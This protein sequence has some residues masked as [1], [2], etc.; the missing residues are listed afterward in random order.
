V[1]DPGP[2]HVHVHLAVTGAFPLQVADLLFADER[3]LVPEYEYVTPLF[4]LARGG[5][6]EAGARARTRHED[7]GVPALLDL[8]ERT[9]RI[10]YDDVERVRVHESRVGRPK[11]AVD[12]ADDPPLG[13]RVHAPVEIDPLAGALRSLGQRRGFPVAERA[14]LGFSPH[15]S[16]RRF[17][18]GR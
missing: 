3:L 6:A 2:V 12:L 17:V 8:A 10:P 16:L 5:L 7:G 1:T 9:L 11:V 18:A 15:N 14:T 13:Y 4:G